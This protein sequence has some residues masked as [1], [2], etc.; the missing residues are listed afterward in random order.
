MVELSRIA[1]NYIAF[2]KNNIGELFVWYFS[3]GVLLVGKS[4][5][6]RFS[7]LIGQIT[8]VHWSA[9]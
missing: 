1:G 4:A 6:L 3:F 8:A 7:A 2:V 5:A 9:S